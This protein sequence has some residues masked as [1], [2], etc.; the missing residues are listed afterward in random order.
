MQDEG[1]AAEKGLRAG[2][3]ILEVDQEEVR[4]PADVNDMVQRARDEQ[5]RVVTLLVMRGGEP[6]WVPVRIDE[7]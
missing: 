5:Y 6:Q 4:S 3:V 7:S 1:S 2:D